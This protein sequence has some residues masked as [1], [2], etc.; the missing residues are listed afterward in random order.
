MQ[1]ID[2]AKRLESLAAHARLSHA[3]WLDNARRGG[4]GGRYGTAY[5]LDGAAVWRRRL[6]ELL[7]ELRALKAKAH[8]A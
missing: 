2:N 5:C 6:A 8:T 4:I 3:Y 1:Q 7:A